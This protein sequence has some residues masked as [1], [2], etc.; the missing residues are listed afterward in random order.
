MTIAD[1]WLSARSSAVLAK[2][3]TDTR[4]TLVIPVGSCE[5]HGPHLP[6]DT[7]TRI[8]V[9]VAEEV[10]RDSGALVAPP[11]AIGA[12]G[13][14]AG[15]V[16]TL[17][18]GTDALASVLAQCL[19]SMGAEFSRALVVNGHGGNA[20]ALER[21]KA[22][23]GPSGEWVAWYSVDGYADAHGGES[24][25]SLALHLFANL[26]GA[27]RP[28]GNTA[29]LAD[30]DSTLRSGGVRSVS[31]NGVLGDARSA[32]AERGALLFAQL[33]ERALGTLSTAKHR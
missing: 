4:I 18:I 24:E 30:L 23:L 22:L 14:H 28:V 19:W 15:F 12:S 31:P 26:V 7:D 1:E 11:I 8:A 21:A 9:A 33:R 32:S 13:E 25:T 5:Q 2:M 16:G 10:A 27:Q 20:E 3:A 29:S 17:S 6:L